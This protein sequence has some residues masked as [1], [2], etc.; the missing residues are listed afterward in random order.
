MNHHKKVFISH[1]ISE[2]SKAV[3]SL[4]SILNKYESP[5]R[6][7]IVTSVPVGKKIEDEIKEHL[8]TT[9]LFLLMANYSTPPKKNEWCVWEMGYYDSIVDRPDGMDKKIISLVKEGGEPPDPIKNRKFVTETREGIQE[10]LKEIYKGIRDDLFQNEALKSDLDKSVTEILE[11]LKPKT[12]ITE[13]APRIWITINKDKFEDFREGKIPLPMDDTM[14]TGETEVFTQRKVCVIDG[15]ELTLRKFS[16]IVD[17]P[18]ALFP[19]YVIL[20]DILMDILNFPRQGPWRIPPLRVMKNMSPRIIVPSALERDVE[21]NYSIEFF[22]TEP[23][24]YTLPETNR[25]LVPLY[26]LLIL[27]WH[28][29]WR[30]IER[31]M[32]DLNKISKQDWKNKM[33]KD[34]WETKIQKSIRKLKVDLE[35]IYLDSY[36]RDIECEDDVIDIFDSPDREIIKNMVCS[37]KSLWRAIKDKLD[38]AITEE[39]LKSIVTCL[40]ALRDIN[41]TTLILTLKKFKELAENE[42]VIEGEIITNQTTCEDILESSGLSNIAHEPAQ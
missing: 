19:F 32:K 17:Y 28:F 11:I 10:L 27:S 1:K 37:D 16:K 35:A 4:K 9:D 33:N 12:L 2:H 3:D 18:H 20:E 29:R 41:K 14:I 21:G 30:V 22:V 24:P 5:Q 38:K 8:N 40:K 7:E 42:K 25:K 36:N 26:N 15:E 31:Y 23:P 39:D 6:L 34:I 13:L